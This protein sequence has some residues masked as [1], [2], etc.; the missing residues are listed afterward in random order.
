MGPDE[1]VINTLQ[2]GVDSAAA[3]F[4]LGDVTDF[5]NVRDSLRYRLDAIAKAYPEIGSTPEFAELLRSLEDLDGILLERVPASYFSQQTDSLAL[6]LN[7][8]PE[9][10]SVKA[11]ALADELAEAAEADSAFPIIANERIDFWMRYFT[12][13]GRERFERALYRMELYRPL[14]EDVMDE[15]DLP[16]ELICVGLIESGF[17]LTARSRAAAVG[18]WQFVSGTARLYGLRVDWWYDERRDIVA[19]SYAAGNYL[20]DL[21][22]IWESWPLALAAYNCGEYRV[23]RAIARQKTENFW[24]LQLPKQTERYVPKFLATLYIV[25]EPE[26]YGFSIPE[27]EPVRFDEITVADATDVKLIAKCAETTVD[28]V[29][30]LNPSLLRWS[31][32]PKMEVMVKVP[33]G[34]GETTS[35]R[36]AEIPPEER[37]TWRKHRIKK[38]ETL[39]VIARQYG[40]SVTAIKDLN[41]IRN[42]HHIRA[43]HSLIVPIQGAYTQ[44]ASAASSKPSYKDTR[45]N[46]SKSELEKYAEKHAPPANHKEVIYRVKDGDTLGEIAEV[47]HTRASR[48]RSWNGLSYRSYIYPGQKLKLYVPESFDLAKVSGANGKPDETLFRRDTYTVRRGDTF[49][50]IS[51]RFN[52]A[53]SDLMA[54]NNKSSRS[55]LYPGQKLEIW[56]RK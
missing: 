44:T 37:V 26:K 8:W 29:Q 55:T 12:G 3:L 28:V 54:W 50:S 47:Y 2:T 52:V 15:L 14:I 38:G 48:I 1:S 45:R 4:D 22:G 41:G 24:Q 34:R 5:V 20:K 53:M 7:E 40:T 10:D 56:Q 36:L 16:R 27:V 6:S 35:Q 19:S 17:T 46:I 13:P 21:Y 33:A 39:S 11:V 25:R 32:P 23:A 9:I 42:A 49:Y 43:G 31:T 18:P 30:E 51:K